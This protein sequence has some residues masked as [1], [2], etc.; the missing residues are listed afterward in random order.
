[1]PDRVLY[2]TVGDRQVRVTRSSPPKLRFW[3]QVN[4]DGPE[5]PTLGKCWVW[6]GVLNK[7]YGC[8]RFGNETH[9]Y[10]ASW[11]IHYGKI[12]EG[13]RVLHKCDNPPCVN[14]E[15][16]F[17]G[18]AADNSA[19]MARKGRAGASKFTFEQVKDIR[20][21]FIGSPGGQHHKG[22]NARQLAEEFGV[23]P[24]AIL[25]VVRRRSYKH[26]E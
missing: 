18:T 7:G 4:K 5:Y 6:T 25:S 22:G 16:L 23:T 1:M 14:P 15:H 24:G 10:R 11:I 8:F 13:M 21:R 19:D 17:L 2:L 20:T 9:A 26:I 3:A 12:P